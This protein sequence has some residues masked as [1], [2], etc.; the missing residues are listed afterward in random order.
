MKF[1][2]IPFVN[3]AP[4][5]HFLSSRWLDEHQVTSGNPRQLGALAKTGKLDAAPFSYVDGLEL[6]AGGEFEWLDS[7][8]IAGFGP[9]RSI[10]LVGATSPVDVAGQ[11]VA[12][13]PQ[14]ATTVRLMEVWLKQ[15][16]KISDFRLV[17]LD[18]PTPLRL[19]IGDEALRRKL[20]YG[21]AEPQ[22][23][24]SEE[25]TAW[26]GKPFVFARWAVRKSIPDRDKMRL[27]IS[28]RSA[29][30]LAQGDW[31]DVSRAQSE[32]TGLPQAELIAYLK[33]IRYQLGPEE[34]AGAQ[35]F[36]Q[37]LELI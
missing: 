12:I 23:D 24:L 10:L 16:H 26:T 25:W 4:Y 28:V 13:S 32:R 1:G 34:L 29:L 18:D 6:V 17:G 21:G 20:E 22:I 9:I 27:A 36:V 33:A 7:M 5:Y 3:M 11:A 31:E 19:I 8:G 35:Q 30:E 15:R 14:T 37:Q 2:T